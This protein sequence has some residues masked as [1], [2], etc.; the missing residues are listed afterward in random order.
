MIVF[1]CSAVAGQPPLLPRN[2]VKTDDVSHRGERREQ[3]QKRVAGFGVAPAV[4]EI[5]V[6]RVPA[7]LEREGADIVESPLSTRSLISSAGSAI[8]NPM[9]RAMQATCR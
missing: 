3:F 8:P 6:E 7:L 4:E 9:H 5:E 1:L 2:V